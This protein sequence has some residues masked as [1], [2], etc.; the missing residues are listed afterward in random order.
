ME[1]EKRN[2]QALI[3][4]GNSI[5][6]LTED[7]KNLREENECF[8]LKKYR[9]FEIVKNLFEQVLNKKTKGR[10]FNI[11]TATWNPITGCLYNCN[12]CW[13]KSLATN[14]L[15]TA[16][17]YAQGFVPSLNETEFTA[18]FAKDDL[19]FVSDMGDM[20]SDYIKSS[21][22]NRVLEHIAKFPEANFLFM[23]KNPQRYHEFLQKM[24]ANAILGATIETNLDSMVLSDKISSAPMPSERY[25]AM[26]TLDWNRKIVSIEPILDF[27]LHTFGE[28]I[29][30]INPF[31]VYVGYDNYLHKLREPPLEKTLKLIARIRENTLVIRKSIRYAW[32]EEKNKI[33][34]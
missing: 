24:P 31:L 5:T 4:R 18:R 32:S 14:K 22:I 7:S 29:E 20:F 30:C 12:Y 9:N 21:W 3:E 16:K 27:D 23:T 25:N 11:V 15:K 2:L 26:K 10:M 6:S 8:S 33:V 1:K 28:W 17:R 34:S 19:I 13:A